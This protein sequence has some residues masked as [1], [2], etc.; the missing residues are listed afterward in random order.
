VAERDWREVLAERCAMT[1]QRQVAEELGVSQSVVNQVL[2]DKYPGDVERVRQLVEGRYMDR[3]VQCP[4]LGRLPLHECLWW[5]AQEW[6]SHNPLRRHMW[7]A[8]RSGC[9]NSR[10]EPLPPPG[11][12]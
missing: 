6:M 4:G 12:R 3:T 11:A 1:T 7:R 9:P 8:C 2:K 5:Q 10:L